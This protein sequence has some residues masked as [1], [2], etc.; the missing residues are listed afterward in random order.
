MNER[1]Q[2]QLGGGEMKKNAAHVFPLEKLKK[3]KNCDI[4]NGMKSMFE[5]QKKKVVRNSIMFL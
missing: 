2:G 3:Q 5:K 1:I 4:Q